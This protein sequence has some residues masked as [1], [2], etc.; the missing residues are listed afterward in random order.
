M[1]DALMPPVEMREE[2]ARLDQKGGSGPADME[3]RLDRLE[4]MVL[5]RKRQCA[6]YPPI[7]PGFDE[8]PGQVRLEL[9]RKETNKVCAVSD[10]DG[11]RRRRGAG[12]WRCLTGRW[13]CQRAY[14]RVA[15]QT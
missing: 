10:L 9:V 4:E 1:A 3:S 6:E 15:T 14:A 5:R 13:R 12:C 2:L 11:V 7:I 8:I